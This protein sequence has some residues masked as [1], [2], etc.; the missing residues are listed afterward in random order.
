MSYE[1]YKTAVCYK[2]DAEFQEPN[3]PKLEECNI[4][5][6]EFC[7]NCSDLSECATC[8][9]LVCDDCIVDHEKNC[10]NEQ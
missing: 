7:E 10:K 6:E 2:C 5:K 9:D 3:I 8:G 1:Y 4:C